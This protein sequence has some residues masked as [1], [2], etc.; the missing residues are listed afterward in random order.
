M[1]LKKLRLPILLIAGILIVGTTGYHLIEGWSWLESIWM[2]VIT[3]TTIGFGEVHTL[4]AA[5][6][7]FTLMLI[8]C[9]LSVVTYSAT[10][11]TRYVLE[12]EFRRDFRRRR[13]R[14]R[15]K[16]MTDH[17]VVA[18]YGRLG[19]EVAAELIDNGQKVVV[20]EQNPVA[21]E[22]CEHAGIPAILGDAS[23][24]AVLGLAHIERARGIAV[25]TR[26][27]AVNVLVTL[28][29]RL[30]NPDLTIFC[31]V[32]DEETASKAL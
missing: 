27:N 13:W 16:R 11:L 15:M 23:S 29:A 28:S 10:Q 3:V 24:D 32:D 7:V 25:A 4:S 9:G 22:Q 30:L 18:G 20:I 21:E 5:G 14:H 19:R 17:F 6:R 8:V 31:R 26:S 2:V 1:L 12:G